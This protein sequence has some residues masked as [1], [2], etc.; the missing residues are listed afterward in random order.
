MVRGNRFARGRE[1]SRDAEGRSLPSD[2]SLQY[3]ELQL[4]CKQHPKGERPIQ[5][6]C[7]RC[8]VP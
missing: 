8:V 1:A 2:T 7:R 3:V 5:C 4:V 6:P